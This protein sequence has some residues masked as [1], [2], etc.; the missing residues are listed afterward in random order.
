MPPTHY[1]EEKSE[2]LFFPPFPPPSMLDRQNTAKMAVATR[3]P[4]FPARVRQLMIMP[5]LTTPTKMESIACAAQE[6]TFGGKEVRHVFCSGDDYAVD[7]VVL[8]VNMQ[9]SC[10]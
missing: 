1:F 8:T 5:A 9:V 7:S 2:A 10:S 6:N 3:A 4:A